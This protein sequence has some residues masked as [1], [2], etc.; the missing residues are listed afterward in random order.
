MDPAKRLQTVQTRCC[1]AGGGPAG[2]ML[3]FLLA[4]AGVDVVVLEKHA[5]F[6]RD[7]RGDTLHP[8]TLGLM[9]ELGLLDAL[10][11]QPHQ[12]VP[13]IGGFFGHHFYPIA[14]F[15]RLRVPCPYIALMPQW[16]FLNFLARQGSRYPGFHL[17]MKSRV[18]GLIHEEG[19]VV[20]VRAQTPE[21]ELE[22]R[23]A[24]VIGADGR[25]STLREAAGL[26]V[27][28]F[29]APIDVLWFRLSRQADDPGQSFGYIGTG[30]MMVMLDRGDYWQCGLIIPKGK[31]AAIRDEGLD[32]F[33]EGL[34]S[35][36][37][38]LN[39]RVD[40]LGSWEVIRLLTVKVDR[41]AQWYQPGLLCIGDAAH[42]MSPVGGVG[43]NLAIQDAV[44]TA[45]LLYKPLLRGD[46][47]PEEL[48]K[49]QERRELPTRATQRL[50]IF[51]HQHFLSRIFHQNQPLAVPWP[52]RLLDRFPFLRALPA[53]LIG[54]GLRPEHIRTPAAR[55]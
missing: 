50:Q 24:L 20:G 44:A 39:E 30:K 41:L 7:F 28:D 22:I 23:A 51:L 48:R 8:S 42:A 49:V 9:G 29:A 19:K 10:L 6:L 21:G 18:S 17:R 53:R 2:M 55:D 36:V 32:A 34:R 15:S 38:F 13:R 45:N 40:E 37:P 43:I 25:G 27:T 35:L 33:R 31:F 47:R 54:L 12:K 14:D 1:I 52:V 46:V 5:D 26:G 11:S 3:G 16:D 4:R